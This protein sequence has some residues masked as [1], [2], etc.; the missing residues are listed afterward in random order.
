MRGVRI[1]HH[2]GIVVDNQDKP[3]VLP[4]VRVHAELVALHADAQK[5][6]VLLVLVPAHALVAHAVVLL[7]AADALGLRTAAAVGEV[8]VARREVAERPAGV[9]NRKGGR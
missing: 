1:L 8:A 4:S 2:I 3:L 5:V 6:R 7:A 9:Q